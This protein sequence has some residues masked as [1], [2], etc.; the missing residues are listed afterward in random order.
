MKQ[1]FIAAIVLLSGCF[2]QTVR[3]YELQS[4]D[5]SIPVMSGVLIQSKDVK[6]GQ[7]FHGTLSES[8]A[9]Q[10]LVLPEGTQFVGH[11][12]DIT[13]LKNWKRF[14][15][16]DI[17]IDQVVFNNG[18]TYAIYPAEQLFPHSRIKPKSK[19]G[20][21]LDITET[22]RLRFTPATL[23]GLLQTATQDKEAHAE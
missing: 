16:V 2:L 23:K 3:A 11:L 14:G 15:A 5:D 1:L 21:L 12:G 17:W 9:Y 20:A 4:L 19:S 10:G 13:P 8:V 6:E 7:D 18:N 22:I